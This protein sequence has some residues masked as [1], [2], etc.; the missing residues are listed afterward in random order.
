MRSSLYHLASLLAYRYTRI[1]SHATT[2]YLPSP[3]SSPSSASE[4][5]TLPATRAGG[6]KKRSE[7][8]RQEFWSRYA[9]KY[10]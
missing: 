2:L 6:L 9:V 1:P 10:R 7:G 5:P 8:G 4:E 3:A